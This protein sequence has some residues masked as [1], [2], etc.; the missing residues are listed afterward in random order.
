MLLNIVAA[1]EGKTPEQVIDDMFEFEFECKPQ[2]EMEKARARSEFP[3]KYEAVRTPLQKLVS[4]IY[5][6]PIIRSIPW[7]FVPGRYAENQRRLEEEHAEDLA[8]AEYAKTV[9]G[10]DVPDHMY[11]GPT[12]LFYKA[13]PH[14]KAWAR[15][16]RALPVRGQ[17]KQVQQSDPFLDLLMNMG[18]AMNIVPA[19]MSTDE[20]LAAIWK[21]DGPAAL[22]NGG[23]MKA[24]NQ[25]TP[26]RKSPLP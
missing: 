2:W 10:Q 23:L 6:L 12:F 19:G 5:D 16:V 20:A 15:R 8:T 11:S 24:A 1:N 9:M 4:P 17:Q 3:A 18:K 13:P 14:M 22:A 26:K 21:M 7:I 25:T